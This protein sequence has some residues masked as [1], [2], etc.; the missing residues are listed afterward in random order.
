MRTPE[1]EAMLTSAKLYPQ[2]WRLLLGILLVVFI[3]LGFSAI[4]FSGLFII[5]GP[6]EFG[7][8]LARLSPA[9]EPIVVSA[10]LLTAIGFLIAALIVAPACHY[11]GPGT[12]FGPR[13]E[14]FR[15]F[16]IT[17]VVSIPLYGILFALA[18]ISG[19]PPEANLPLYIWLQWLPLAVPLILLQVS[20]E[21][22][23][24]RGYLPQQLA[25][26]FKA[27]IIWMGLPAVLFGALH[28]NP[29]AGDMKWL[30]I[31]T[32]FFIGL[33][34]M[35]L[36]ERTGSLGAAI[37]LHFVNNLSAILILTSKDSLSGLALWVSPVGFGDTEIAAIGL[38]TNIIFLLILWR[39]IRWAL[40]R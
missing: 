34:A 14:T 23:I 28:F 20:G 16:F 9:D 38:G 37:G 6:F 3:Y 33:I 32:T 10:L 5:G 36:T 29:A 21:E 13:D 25:A 24:F 8:W 18:S 27:R 31:F 39:V 26:R 11:R 1:F 19:A 7:F 4:L 40:E 17:V 30:I 15:G 35:D 22:L 2:I 12:L